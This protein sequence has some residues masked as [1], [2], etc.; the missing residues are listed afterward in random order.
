MC[1][2][3][4]LLPLVLGIECACAELQHRVFVNTRQFIATETSGMAYER[5]NEYTPPVF[6]LTDEAAPIASS[7]NQGASSGAYPTI[8]D[9]V[10]HYQWNTQHRPIIDGTYN[11]DGATDNASTSYL[12]LSSSSSIDHERLS[13]NH[14]GMEESTAIIE[15]GATIPETTCVDQWKTQC[16]SA[17]GTP[18]VS[19]H[20]HNTETGRTGFTLPVYSSSLL[21]S[22]CYA[23]M[24]EPL[25]IFGNDARG[26]RSLSRPRRLTFTRG[27]CAQ[28]DDS[29]FDY[30]LSSSIYGAQ[31]GPNPRSRSHS[32]SRPQPHFRSPRRRSRSTPKKD[33][34]AAPTTAALKGRGPQQHQRKTKE[35]SLKRT[36]T[37]E[38]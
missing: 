33:Q 5:S 36:K 13:A 11:V 37:N 23:R 1:Q 16:Y 28:R 24:L 8:S 31:S 14:A 3:L 7:Y 35:A 19:G 22:T 25:D 32:C 18:T 26:A 2:K 12:L 20:T 17:N 27:G 15:D 4:Y 29:E 10:W 38:N 21:A 34:Q 6:S 9:D 30:S